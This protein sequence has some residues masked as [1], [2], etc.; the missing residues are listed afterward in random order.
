MSKEAVVETVKISPAMVRRE[1]IRGVLTEIAEKH[2]GY[3]SPVAVLE[4]ARNP[5]SVLHEE[6]EWDDSEAGEK[7]RLLQAA[8]II[9]KARITI[10]RK[11]IQA[12]TVR[13]ETTREYQSRPSA[14]NP[15][16]GYEH[17]Q[18]ILSDEEKKAEMLMQC[19]KELEAIQRRYR[20]LEELSS[21]WASIDAARA[22][23]KK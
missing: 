5:D 8:A 16:Q 1:K 11:E 21:V 12:K 22:G 23:V 14:R 18:T 2:D 17:V 19:F 9:R 7:Y 3:L 6:F 10:V 15:E 13:I 4:A 20:Q